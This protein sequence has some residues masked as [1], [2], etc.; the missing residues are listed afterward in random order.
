MGKRKHIM[1]TK[2]AMKRKNPRQISSGLGFDMVLEKFVDHQLVA[3]AGMTLTLPHYSR[4]AIATLAL[5]R[6]DPRCRPH[7]MLGLQISVHIVKSFSFLSHN[8]KRVVTF[9]SE[10]NYSF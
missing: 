6:Y 10:G 1:A 5:G 7:H 8:A 9:W 2:P 3:T 4:I